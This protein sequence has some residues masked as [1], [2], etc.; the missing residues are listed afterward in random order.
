M[1]RFPN[2][3]D[4][5]GVAPR[6]PGGP[7]A[8]YRSRDPA[9]IRAN[10]EAAAATAE[11]G[12]T[13]SIAASKELDYIDDSRAE[14]AFNKLR[15]KQMQLTLDPDRGYVHQRGRLA[16][17]RPIPLVDEY[18]KSFDQAV[19]E[20]SSGLSTD[21]Q[22]RK[23][24]ER[25]DAASIGFRSDILR[26]VMRETDKH[27]IEVLEGVLSTEIQNAGANWGD[28]S[29][30]DQA[31]ARI[32]YNI[33]K[34][35]GA[36]GAA[37]EKAKADLAASMAKVHDAV[38]SSAI[39]SGAYDY[40]QNYLSK[41]SKEIGFA[42]M[43]KHGSL[44]RK[45]QE[46][47]TAN[48]IAGRVINTV[49]PAVAPD[50]FDRL[51]SLVTKIESNGR[52]YDG[53]GRP[54]TSNKGAKYAQQVMPFTAKDPGFGVKPAKD[55]SPAEYNRVGREYL[56]AMLRRYGG[57]IQKALAAYNAGPG[58]VD[59]ALAA[60][61]NPKSDAKPWLQRLPEETQKYVVKI[62]S[63][64]EA[65]E[66]GA[67]RPTTMDVKK[68][69][70]TAAT[71]V[72]L[73][74][75]AVLKAGERAEAMLADVEKSLGQQSDSLLTDIMSRVDS[76]EITQYG[77]LTPQELATLG[78]KRTSVRSYIEAN[79]RR[80]EK[81]L[82]LSVAG[83][84]FYYNLYTDPVALKSSNVADIMA[85]APEIGRERVNT[86]LQKRA[87]YINRPESEKIAVLD[88]DQFRAMAMRMGFN[89]KSGEAK[90]ELILIK[91]RAEEAITVKQGELKR[92]LT[93]EEK[94]EVIKR[95]MVEV[96]AVRAR[97]T[98]VFGGGATTMT[99]R[100][101][102]IENPENVIIPAKD[103]ASIIAD[104]RRYGHELTDAEIRDVYV[105][106]LI[107]AQRKR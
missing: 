29:V 11:L 76:G 67:M 88:A 53:D 37:G 7:L 21:R 78:Q 2:F 105:R 81:A 74:P 94:G 24:K 99:K 43:A 106:R 41:N 82:Q 50:D 47:Q 62:S 65:G 25:A 17:E 45:M 102:D 69:A 103:K 15:E 6:D 16:V 40:A 63:Q 60:E 73:S 89:P 85:L 52:D 56:G 48:N 35:Y 107:A 12:R 96:P 3:T 8:S 83:T 30:I 4:I 33:G 28:Q 93:R 86:L 87:E 31:R 42:D 32:E 9:P 36:T 38:V 27:R 100:G 1:P 84:S 66:V 14:S 51:N 91:D 68:A 13:I 10:T 34:V 19:S 97:Y 64:Y 22:R 79:S 44:L 75:D 95:M 98:G 59:S 104:A 57:D 72:G 26:H 49:L 77:D 58:A 92:T 70:M 23:F 20:I 5:G 46:S 18:G 39:A 101:Y 61:K 90:K 71:M 55:D 80:G 54:V